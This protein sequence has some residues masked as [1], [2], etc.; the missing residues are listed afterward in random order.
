[1]DRDKLT[2]PTILGKINLPVEPPKK[3]PVASS[4]TIDEDKRKKKRKR[5]EKKV[6]GTDSNLPARPTEIRTEPWK[7]PG[8][9]AG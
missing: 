4:S 7:R 9:P 1:M 3:K 8:G 2:G 5:T 6:T